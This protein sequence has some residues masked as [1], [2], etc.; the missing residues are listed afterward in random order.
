MKINTKGHIT[1]NAWPHVKK[2]FKGLK[3]KTHWKALVV[4]WLPVWAHSVILWLSLEGVGFG[5]AVKNK[6]K[7]NLRGVYEKFIGK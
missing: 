7:I 5:C 1:N 4:S 3:F 6:M 2:T